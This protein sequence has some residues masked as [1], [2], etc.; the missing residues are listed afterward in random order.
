V[1]ENLLGTIGNTPVVKLNRVSEGIDATVLVKLEYFNPAGSVKDRMAAAIVEDAERRGELKQ[2]GTIIEATSGNTG[3]GLALVAAVKGYKV[4]L[5][6]PNKISNERVSLLKALG[7]EVILTPSGVPRD[8]AENHINVAKKL[9]EETPNSFF[10]NQY[11]NKMNPEAHYNTTGPEIW[12][13]TR[14]MLDAFVAGIGTGGTITGVSKYLKEKKSRVRIIG[15]EPEGSTISGGEEKPF[16]LEGIGYNFIPGTLSLNLLDEVVKV[17]DRDAFLMARRLA[18][19]EGILVGGS[20]GAAVFA[21][22][23]VARGLGRG[24]MVLALL[25]DTGRNYL[26][27]MFSDEWMREKFLE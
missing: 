20:S 6:I 16:E 24:S 27:K 10:S 2:G 15:V 21:A 7:A 14:G 25:P 4:K 23:N 18:R 26:S 13:Q 9:A 22:L 12:E 19:E 3:I 5:A 8:S 17:S 1:H 11:Y